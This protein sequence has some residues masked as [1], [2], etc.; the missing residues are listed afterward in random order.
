VEKVLRIRCQ[1]CHGRTP[2]EGAN[3][4]LLTRADLTAPSKL[5]PSTTVAARSLKRMVDALAP[6]PPVPL[7]ASTLADITALRSWLQVGMPQSECSDEPNPSEDPYDAAAIC[8]SGSFWP[9]DFDSGNW[10]MM[11][12]RQCL[13][14]HKQFFQNAPLFSVAG[15][16]YPTAHEPDRCYGVP[17]ATGA[18]VVITD[19]NGV[20]HAPV[21][22]VSGGNFGAILSGLALPYRAKIVVGGVERVML[23]PQTNGDCNVCHS[24]AG[25]QGAR[26]RIIL[27]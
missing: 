15:T 9:I 10:G 3:V 14:C 24:Q 20:E 13:Q 22:V 26:G 19:A 1:S 7:P 25:T 5:L 17:V 23:T 8:T 12:G 11:P 4:S 21:P 6:M 18:K 27:P 16:L 2:I